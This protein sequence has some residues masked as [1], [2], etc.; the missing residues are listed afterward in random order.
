MKYKIANIEDL[1]V[2]LERR[3]KNNRKKKYSERISELKSLSEGQEITDSLVKFIKRTFNN[4]QDYLIVVIEEEADVDGEVDV[5]ADSGADDVNDGQPSKVGLAIVIVIVIAVAITF[6][7]FIWYGVMAK[8]IKTANNSTPQATTQT[9][10]PTQAPTAKP[11]QKP[12]QVST[13]APAELPTFKGVAATEKTTEKAKS[14]QT[15]QAQKKVQIPQQR[16]VVEEYV[17]AE[18]PQ[19][20][21]IPEPTPSPSLSPSPQPEEEINSSRDSTVD[22]GVTGGNE[23]YRASISGQV[24]SPVPEKIFEAEHPLPPAITQEEI[25]DIPPVVLTPAS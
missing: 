21:Y 4:Y 18:T 11:T 12:T 16:I 24:E 22:E 20:S 2:K 5:G 23:G 9:I 25:E 15:Q 14:Q 8:K 3:D 17:V 6:A 19:Q 7:M 10:T 1:I 13:Q